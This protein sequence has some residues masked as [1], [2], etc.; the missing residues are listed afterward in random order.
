MDGIAMGSL[1]APDFLN[2][3]NKIKFNIKFKIE[4]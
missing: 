1:L 2:F 3:L 4:N